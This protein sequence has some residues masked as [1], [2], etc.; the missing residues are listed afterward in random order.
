[1]SRQQQQFVPLCGICHEPY[2][3]PIMHPDCVSLSESVRDDLEDLEFLEK[4]MNFGARPKRHMVRV[5]AAFAPLPSL[6]ENMPVISAFGDR[7][8]TFSR[9][10]SVEQKTHA[11]ELRRRSTIVQDISRPGRRRASVQVNPLSQEII[12]DGKDI[13]S[14]YDADKPANS[15]LRW[16]LLWLV[17]CLLAPYPLWLTFIPGGCAL[18]YEITI[19]MNVLLTSNFIYTTILC[20]QYMWRMIR[21]FNTPFWQELDP[22]TRAK[23]RH[24]VVMPTYKEPVELLC[25][26]LSSIANQT[27]SGSIIMVVGM[28]ERTPD[29]D[30][31]QQV[32]KERF[33]RKFCALIFSVHPTGI[34]GEIPGAC[35]NRNYAARTAVKY[36]ISEGLLP[37]DP[38][39]RELELDFCT[40]SVCDADTT[41]YYRYFENLSW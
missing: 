41:Y 2:N 11:F 23:L 28:E 35:S 19:L 21:A 33:E 18:S 20:W 7:T 8:K 22:E 39:S 3:E 9:R 6:D 16:N 4:R 27:V 10:P 14:T 30:M 32:I 38:V 36:M 17:F 25:E 37:V 31:K 12:V 24:I 29:Q 1:M 34:P 5:S 15:R 26:T 40:I 13:F